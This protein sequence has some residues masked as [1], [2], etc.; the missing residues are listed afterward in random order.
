[1]IKIKYSAVKLINI[2]YFNVGSFLLISKMMVKKYLFNISNIKTRFDK[3]NMLQLSNYRYQHFRLTDQQYTGTSKVILEIVVQSKEAIII[4]NEYLNRKHYYLKKGKNKIEV[5]ITALEQGENVLAYKGKIKIKYLSF[6]KLM[7]SNESDISN[8][9]VL[10]IHIGDNY[11]QAAVQYINNS[12][13]EYPL[14]SPFKNSCYAIYDYDNQC[15]RMSYWLWSDAPIV[16]ALL[17]LSE[18]DSINKHFYISLASKIGDTL[19]RNQILDKKDSNYGALVSRYRYLGSADNSFDCLLGVN[20]TSFAVKWA[21]LSLYKHTGLIEYLNAS[22][23]A[24]DWV[25][26]AIYENEFV[27]SHFYHEKGKREDGCFIDTG[28]TT[29]GLAEYNRIIIDKKNVVYSNA[30][31]FFMRRFLKQFQLKNGFYGQ[32]YSFKNGIS[33]KLFTRGHGWVLEGL[34]ASY[35]ET[36]N[37]NYLNA[38]TSLGELL[39]LEQEIDGSWPYLLGYVYPLTSVKKYSGKCEKATALLSYLFIELY[40]LTNNNKF[41]YCSKKAIAWC[42]RNMNSENGKG[43]GG[44]A[45]KNLASGITGLPFI[46]TA[47]GYANAFYIISKLMH[48]ELEA[49]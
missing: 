34:I 2:K 11:L 44:I 35:K 9:N 37:H 30:I 23:I 32:Y 17:K 33:H 20:D 25:V 21:L 39:I 36:K 16:Y 31:N 46:K 40:K 18:K 24:L 14:H 48:E 38:A 12:L 1:M 41:I 28:F 47:T 19:L 8:N 13:V 49:L 7:H 43:Y 6:C 27:P 3:K 15:F 10:L 5:P 22:K 4:I 45:S 42:E 29:E 26:K